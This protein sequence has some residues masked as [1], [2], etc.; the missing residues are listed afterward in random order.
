MFVDRKNQ[1][2]SRNNAT[3]TSGQSWLVRFFR[4]K[5]ETNAGK[6][7][8]RHQKLATCQG[9]ATR[10]KTEV[11]PCI[12]FPKCLCKGVR[13]RNFVTRLL[14][15][16]R[17]PGRCQRYRLVIPRGQSVLRC[18]E[19]GQLLEKNPHAQ[20]FPAITYAQPKIGKFDGSAATRQ[21]RSTDDP[22]KR[23]S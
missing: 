19:G 6:V 16:C 17:Y 22:F 2:R 18:D 5:T 14:I 21:T 9:P 1:I 15:A 4:L 3:V 8:I 11:P 10:N 13:L 20:K 7:R 23:S 12:Q